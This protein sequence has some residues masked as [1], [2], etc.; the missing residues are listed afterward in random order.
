MKIVEVNNGKLTKRFI[1]FPHDLYEGDPNYVPEIYIGQK[2]LMSPKKNPFF[3]HSKVEFDVPSDCQSC[4][5]PIDK[6]PPEEFR[7]RSR[8]FANT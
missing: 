7:T 2:E 6:R 5:L 4:L 1:D 3:K 8:W